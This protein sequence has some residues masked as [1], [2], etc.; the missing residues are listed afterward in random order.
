M[1]GAAT[2]LQLFDKA[3]EHRT[4]RKLAALD[5]MI[6]A[7]QFLHHDPARA[8]VEVPDF[9]IAHLAGRQA[10]IVAGGMEQRMW[11]RRP[12]PIESRRAGLQDRIVGLLLAPAPAVQDDQH[13]GAVC[14]HSGLSLIGMWPDVVRRACIFA[15]ELACLRYERKAR[16]C[17]PRRCRTASRYRRTL[18]DS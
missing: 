9:R 18:R 2:L 17:G 16:D 7:R 13:D 6:D 15:H 4:F 8:D 12:E 1:A 10:D 14:R 3:P 11:A 5:C